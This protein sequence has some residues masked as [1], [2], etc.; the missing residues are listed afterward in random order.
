MKVLGVTVDYPRALLASLAVVLFVAVVVAASTSSAAFGVY[1]TAW[2]GAGQLQDVAE[3]G[4]ANATVVLNTS[5]YG[6]AE[7]NQ[8]VAVVLSPNEAYGRDAEA[9]RQFVRNGGTLVVAEDFG[10]NGNA[11]LESVGATARFDGRIVRDEKN[12]ERA[13]ALPVADNVTDANT[14]GNLTDDV[15][16]VAL[17]YGTVVQPNDATVLV[18]TSEFAYLDA[19]R[20]EQIDDGE[21]LRSYPV[22]TVE[23][24]GAG[25]VVA[26]SDPSLFINAMLDREDNRQFTANLLDRETVLLDYSHAD[27]QPPLTVAVLQVRGSPA[28]Q[29]GVVALAIGLVFGGS[30]LFGRG[31]SDSRRYTPDGDRVADYLARERG[32]DAERVK[33]LT[34]G[35]WG[36]NPQEDDNE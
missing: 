15:E 4:G 35:V 5:A 19:N 1:N 8:T 10:P 26:V 25:R 31:E 16:S 18:G 9:L 12:Y 32:W 28:L 21:P 2:D 11:L 7:P 14:T 34:T 13:P 6:S 27:G 20:N 22:A 23:S 33:R 3:E 30:R 36:R 29:G 24:V 17:N